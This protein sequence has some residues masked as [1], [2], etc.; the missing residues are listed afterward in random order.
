MQRHGAQ[1]A[2]S[3]RIRH[4]LGLSALSPGSERQRKAAAHSLQL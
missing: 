2:D 3:P 1:S 4:S